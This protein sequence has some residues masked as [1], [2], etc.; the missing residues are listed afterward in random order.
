[1]STN[2]MMLYIKLQHHMDVFY[3][4]C[5]VFIGFP[6]LSGATAD[7]VAVVHWHEVNCGGQTTVP[8]R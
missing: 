4:G 7:T 1:M 2:D 5:G 3:S 8:T 6:S